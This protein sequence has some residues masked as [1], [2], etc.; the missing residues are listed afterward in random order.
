MDTNATRIPTRTA[1]DA[2]HV[3]E[4]MHAG[5]ITCQPDTP[6][7]AIARIMSDERVHCV[8]VLS[9]P[10]EESLAGDL[11]GVVSDIDVAG[12][13]SADDGSRTASNTAATPVVTVS[14]AETLTRAAQLMVEHSTGHLVVVDPTTGRP[15]GVISTLD[16]ARVIGT[17]TTS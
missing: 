1:L 9:A 3:G 2:V 13:V 8:I 17:A 16:V 11:W 5:V 7:Q 15:L 10:E 4:A 6:L 14:P 12:A